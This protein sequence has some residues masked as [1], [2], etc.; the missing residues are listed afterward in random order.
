MKQASLFANADGFFSCEE[1]MEFFLI[2][3]MKLITK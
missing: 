3:L 2:C 1:N